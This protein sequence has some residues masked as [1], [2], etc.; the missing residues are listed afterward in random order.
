M[1]GWSSARPELVEGCAPFKQFNPK[2]NQRQSSKNI[3]S[4]A[5]QVLKLASVE[6][7]C[8]LAVEYQKF[9]E[10]KTE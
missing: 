10:R 3:Q 7:L 9:S 8:L 5:G 1:T 2:L 4:S 6:L